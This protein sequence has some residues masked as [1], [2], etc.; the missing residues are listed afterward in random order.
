MRKPSFKLFYKL[1]KAFEEINKEENL[2]Q[3]LVPYFISSH[4]GCGDMDMA[5]LAAET[6]KLDFK[7]EQIQDFTRR[8]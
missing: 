2:N 8:Q 3:Q 1:A 6:K 5:N 4:P 7:L